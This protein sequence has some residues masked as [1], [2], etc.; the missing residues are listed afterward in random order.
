MTPKTITHDGFSMGT[1]S[2]CVFF[3]E[4][5]RAVHDETIGECRRRSPQPFFYNR[6]SSD[7]A[8]WPVVLASDGCGEFV[9]VSFDDDELFTEFELVLPPEPDDT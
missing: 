2:K 1:C 6:E 4:H 3:W 8:L 9:P 7:T 5:L